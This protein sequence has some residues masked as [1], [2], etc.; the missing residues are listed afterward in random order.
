MII[1]SLVNDVLIPPIGMRLGKVDCSHL[2]I[3]LQEKT[4]EADAVTVK[5]GMF[6]NT[7]LD[8]V[9]VAFAIFLLIKQVNRFKKKEPEPEATTKECPK[10]FST[11]PI[12]ATRCPNCTSEL[13]IEQTS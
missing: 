5:Y 11:I 12:K 1:N 7:I 3:T 2:A 6:I 8:F 10:C 13:L 4:A 9:I